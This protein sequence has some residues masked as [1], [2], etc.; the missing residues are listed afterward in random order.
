MGKVTIFE[1]LPENHSPFFRRGM[2]VGV[3]WTA[4]TEGSALDCYISRDNVEQ[5]RLICEHFGYTCEI[6][7]LEEPD[8]NYVNLIATPIPIDNVLL[9]P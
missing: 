7:E 4:F 2:E 9:N 5:I 3:C 1:F 8:E 6:R